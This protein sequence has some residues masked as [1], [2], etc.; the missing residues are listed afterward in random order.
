[1]FRSKPKKPTSLDD[2]NPIEGEGRNGILLCKNH[3]AGFMLEVTGV[4][5]AFFEESEWRHLQEACRSILR[6]ELGESLQ[7]VFSKRCDFENFFEERFKEME[8]VQNPFTRKLFLYNLN[9]IARNLQLERPLLFTTK[10]IVT[11]MKTFKESDSQ[12]SMERFLEEKRFVLKRAFEA[13]R[14]RARDITGTEV[15]SQIASAA[16]GVSY[17]KSQGVYDQWP[18]VSISPSQLLVEDQIF[19]SLALKALPESHSEMGMMRTLTTV[20][21]PFDLSVRFS[22]TDA[23]PIRKRLERKKQ[24]LFGL[25]AGK[26]AGDPGLEV[27][28]EELDELLRRLSD[29]NDALL[30]MSFCIGFRAKKEND[31][32]IRKA[33]TDVLSRQSQLGHLQFD[34]TSLVTFDCFLETIPGFQ[35]KQFHSHTILASNAAHFLPIFENDR[36]DHRGVAN[37]RT[38]TGSL[39]SINPISSQLANFNWLVSGTSGSGKSF[40]VNS[41]LAQSMSLDPRIFIIDIGGSYKKLTHFLGG[42]N[43]GLDIQN[44]FKMGPFFMEKSDDPAEERRRRE[45]IEIVFGEMLRDE[46]RLPSIE[47]RALLKQALQP[48]LDADVVP[49]RPITAVRNK[50]KEMDPVLAKRLILLLDRWCYPSFFGDFLDNPVAIGSSHKIVNYDL[51]SLNEF[52]DLSRVVQLIICSS[53]WSRVRKDHS[54][55]TFIVLD[56]VA[57]SLLKS[58]PQFVDELVSTVRKHN[59]GVVLITQDLEKVTSNLAGASI[60]QNTQIKA[61]LQQRGNPKNYAEPLNLMAAELEAIQSLD[62]KKGSFS[63]IFLMI[64]DRRSVIRFVPNMLEYFLG[65][66]VPH[67]NRYLEENLK[68]FSGSFQEKLLAFVKEQTS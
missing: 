41:L 31:I 34:E 36:G 56:E 14:M 29:R 15:K 67:E 65:T 38:R 52:E 63:D 37:F 32:Y 51:K 40:F 45:H 19:R 47:E 54:K 28:I 49:E 20:F 1:M 7:F 60:L 68:R 27:R 21:S 6:L 53:L 10:L 64:D 9:D 48:F 11:F 57:F 39:F 22:G 43:I 2:F 18:A 8:L 24:V 23:E 33:L 30:E 35:G 12:E 5:A 16:S 62:R 66:S 50:L 3:Q 46:N 61:I 42:E 17:M 26:A 4:D 44:G 13:A 58:Q 59:A 55:F 25:R